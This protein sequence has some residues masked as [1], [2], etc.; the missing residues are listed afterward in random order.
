MF[1]FEIPPN[2]TIFFFVKL[3]NNLNLFI[4]KKFLFFLNIDDKKILST[5]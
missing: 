2:G 3:D 5:F 1:F 4:P